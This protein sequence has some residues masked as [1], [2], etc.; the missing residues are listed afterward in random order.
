MPSVILLV[1]IRGNK[2]RDFES[3]SVFITIFKICLSYTLPKATLE[4]KIDEIQSVL[5]ER[6]YTWKL[7]YRKAALLWNKWEGKETKKALANSTKDITQWPLVSAF[8]QTWT[9]KLISSWIFVRFTKFWSLRL[10]KYLRNWFAL[11]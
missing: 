1:R 9:S 6:P 8:T 2:K 3:N 5:W 10:I 11:Q 7:R 4:N